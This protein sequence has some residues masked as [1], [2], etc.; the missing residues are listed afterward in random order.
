MYPMESVNH[1]EGGEGF[2]IMADP[3]ILTMVSRKERIN[4]DLH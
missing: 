3:P 2:P 4:D 1:N